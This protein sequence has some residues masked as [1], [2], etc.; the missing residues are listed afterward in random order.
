MDASGRECTAQE[1]LEIAMGTRDDKQ[2][3]NG[4]L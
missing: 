1:E 2:K 4:I 3:I